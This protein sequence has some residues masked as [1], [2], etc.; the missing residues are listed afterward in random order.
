[1]STLNTLH[2]VPLTVCCQVYLV[3]LPS[4][5]QKKNHVSKATGKKKFLYVTGLILFF[6]LMPQSVKRPA[7]VVNSE[8]KCDK[9]ILLGESQLQSP[10]A[11]KH[12]SGQSVYEIQTLACDHYSP[13]ILSESQPPQDAVNSER[14]STQRS[15][16]RGRTKP[17][18]DLSSCS[19]MY[20]NLLISSLTLPPPPCHLQSDWR[21]STL[22]VH[23]VTR[24]P[25]VDGKPCA[26]CS[27]AASS[28]SPLSQANGVMTFADLLRQHQ[29]TLA[30]SQSAALLP[31][32]AEVASSHRPYYQNLCNSYPSLQP[33]PLPPP[34][35]FAAP[36]SPSPH[37]LFV[38]F[39]YC[40][41]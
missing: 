12:F 2:I 8:I 36:S 10:D 27:T 40:R 3:L 23:G 18:G 35:A 28:E 37:S 13:F 4:S 34:A 41:L 32:P 20:A 14:T 11:D 21:P 7:V 5:G 1:M 26:H 19:S 25:G 33:S 22:C 39:S 38:D 31:C 6:C 17:Y 30:F 16:A 15:S 29:S 9:L 24:R